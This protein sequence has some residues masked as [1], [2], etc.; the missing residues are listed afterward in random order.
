MQ[1]G[2]A[3]MRLFNKEYN[4]FEDVMNVFD[5]VEVDTGLRKYRSS[6]NIMEYLRLVSNH[7]VSPNESCFV[8]YNNIERF[9]RM[10]TDDEFR[11]LEDDGGLKHEVIEGFLRMLKWN[12]SKKEFN[13][14]TS[15]MGLIDGECRSREEVAHLLEMT[16]NAVVK[17]EKEALR[18]GG[19]I[20]KNRNGRLIAFVNR[21]P[22]SET[23][24]TPSI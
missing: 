2:G 14:I 3:T 20:F 4:L 16:E 18:R 21:E 15:R 10:A 9:R 23:E 17:N 24:A 8:T 5:D 7:V 11:N 12:L 6:F 1:I 19:N 22:I 13:V